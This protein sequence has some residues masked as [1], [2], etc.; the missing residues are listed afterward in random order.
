[1]YEN[2]KATI[3]DVMDRGTVDIDQI[4]DERAIKALRKWTNEF[5][6]HQHPTVIEVYNSLPNLVKYSFYSQ[7]N[8]YF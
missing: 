8:C 4:N 1:M 2:M 7:I 3:K 5:T 6:R